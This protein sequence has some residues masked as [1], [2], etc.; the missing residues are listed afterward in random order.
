MSD[1]AA[2]QD[3]H[4]TVAEYKSHL[5]PIWCPGCGDFGV[6]SAIYNA[7]SRLRL[8]PWEAVIVSGIGCSSRLPDFVN[9][10]GYHTIHG[11]A[12]P[13]ATGVKLANPRLTVLA[14]G[15][16]GDGFAIGGGHVPHAAR[17]NLDFTY[18]VMD[19]STYGLTKGQP[20]PTSPIGLKTKASP[21]GVVDEPLNLAALAVMYGATFVGRG[22]SGKLQDLTDLIVKGIEHEGFAFVH[23]LSPCTTFHDTWQLYKQAIT[24]VPESHDPS[25][26]RAALD[27]TLSTSPGIPIGLLYQMRKP[28]FGEKLDATLSKEKPSTVEALFEKYYAQKTV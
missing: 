19:N 17:R 22:F 7:F 23:V 5:K 25:D 28:T 9:A 3:F 16:D 18:I 20:S 14:V 21:N 10:Y 1:L 2:F 27:L 6:V 8:N 11:R 13:I 4:Y 24:K 26:F 12:L 15:G